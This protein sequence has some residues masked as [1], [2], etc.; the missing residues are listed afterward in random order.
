MD[1]YRFAYRQGLG[2]GRWW[3]I[4]FTVFSLSACSTIGTGLAPTSTAKFP[5]PVTTLR[6]TPVVMPVTTSLPGTPAWKTYQNER[7]GYAIEYPADWEIDEA[8]ESDGAEVTTFVPP[9]SNKNGTELTVITRKGTST[10]EEIPDMPNTRCRQVTVGKLSGTRCFD[11]IAFSTM[12]TFVGQGKIYI[13]VGSG[14]RL[15]QNIYQHFLNS[16]ALTP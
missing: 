3:V 14:K 16:F 4:A 2:L 10:A 13:L 12:T 7:A 1:A 15:D 5:T 6:A 9:S 11:T 8:T